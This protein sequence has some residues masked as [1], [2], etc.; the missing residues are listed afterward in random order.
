MEL[1]SCINILWKYHTIY[2]SYSVEYIESIK[3]VLKFVPPNPLATSPCIVLSIIK[4]RKYG[5]FATFSSGNFWYHVRH[6][7]WLPPPHETLKYNTNA[8]WKC[9]FSLIVVAAMVVHNT[10]GVMVDGVL[11]YV[12]SYSPI[13]A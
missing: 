5:F 4:L 2:F 8:N 6:E 10:N 9:Q 7:I 11:K 1:F 13:V 12:W 3:K